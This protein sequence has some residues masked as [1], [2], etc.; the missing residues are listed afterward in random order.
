MTED[1]TNTQHSQQ[2]PTPNP[3]LKRLDRLVGTWKQ[4]GG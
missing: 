4:S 2:T 1:I 3:D